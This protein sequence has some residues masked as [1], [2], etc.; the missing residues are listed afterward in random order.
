MKDGTSRPKEENV[1]EN[2]LRTE[3]WAGSRRFTVARP[4][5]R[6]LGSPE[7]ASLA[8]GRRL[9]KPRANARRCSSKPAGRQLN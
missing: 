1:S 8:R 2:S 3:M 9:R 7:S 5:P 4:T 6:C